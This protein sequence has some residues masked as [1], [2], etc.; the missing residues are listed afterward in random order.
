MDYYSPQR[1]MICVAILDLTGG[2]EWEMTFPQFLEFL[3]NKMS[4][5]P[6]EFIDSVLVI[7]KERDM[8]E[9]YDKIEITA[10]YERPE[11]DDEFHRRITLLAERKKSDEL[12]SE[13]RDRQE[14]A[15]L[16]IKY[17]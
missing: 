10:S 16:K 8:G 12:S 7:A 1:Q 14:Y 4:S 9:C 13:L 6:K 2:D 5:V 11:T 15:R 3:E 17:G